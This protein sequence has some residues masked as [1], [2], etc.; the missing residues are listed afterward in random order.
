ML[1]YT[2]LDQEPALQERREGSF[3]LP[4]SG[5]DIFSMAFFTFSQQLREMRLEVPVIS[6]EIFWPSYS[7]LQQYPMWPNMETL[8]ISDISPS[9]LDGTPIMR[10]LARPI[11]YYLMCVSLT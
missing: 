3:L 8:E 11:K 1:Y 5:E 4:P 9:K 2:R 6:S 10:N 7:G